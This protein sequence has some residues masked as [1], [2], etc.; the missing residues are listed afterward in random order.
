MLGLKHSLLAGVVVHQIIQRREPTILQFLSGL[1]LFNFVVFLQ[2]FFSSTSHHSELFTAFLSLRSAFFLSSAFLLSLLLSIVVYRLSPIHPLAG[3]P[4]PVPAK[5]SK[6]WVAWWI[7][8]GDRHLV[9]QKLH[10]QYGPWLR[11]G[12]NELSVNLPSAV[13]PIYSQMFRAPFYQGSPQDADALIT[14]TSRSEHASRLVSWSKAFS[15]EPLRRFRE[16]AH[17]RTAQLVEILHRESSSTLISDGKVDLSHWIPLWSMDVMGDMSFSGGFEMLAAGKDSEGWM[18]ALHKGVMFVVVIGQLPWLRDLIALLPAPGPII[19]FRRFANSKVKETRS[20]SDEG[21]VAGKLNILGIIQNPSSSGPVLTHAEAAADASFIV[22]AGSNTVSEGS[23]ALLRY[24]IGDR[25]IQDHIRKELAALE[26]ED[27]DLEMDSGS[28]KL[29]RLEYLD[30]C[31]MEALRI[32]PPVAAGPPRY[33]DRPT[34]VLDQVIPQGTTVSCPIW[35]MHRDP[36][37]FTQPEKFIPERWLSNG[38]HPSLK[39]MKGEMEYLHNTEAFV[40]FTYGPVVCI[41]KPV[42]LHNMKYLIAKLLASFEIEFADRFDVTA[43]DQSWKEHNLW[44]HNPLAVKMK[45]LQ[46]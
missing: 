11:I 24:I 35:T 16:L 10:E 46:M 36:A 7:T 29:A 33:A 19:T 13:R 15:S 8:K 20:N 5:I 44:I 38:S 39:N 4:G 22:I 6:W 43:F 14:T 21:G 32:M 2:A 25:Q 30:A 9:L 18:E 40:P 37:N 3:Y 12:P 34:Q 31:V 45:P 41:G 1:F 26:K 23:T 42:A 27:V 17:A 28:A